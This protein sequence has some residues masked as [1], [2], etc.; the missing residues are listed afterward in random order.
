MP[1]TQRDIHALALHH[2]LNH[3]AALDLRDVKVPHEMD[4]IHKG[5][6]WQVISATLFE[7]LD[8]MDLTRACTDLNVHEWYNGKLFVHVMHCVY[9]NQLG[10]LKLSAET[11][12]HVTR[13]MQ[14]IVAGLDSRVAAV[15]QRNKAATPN[16]LRPTSA[17]NKAKSDAATLNHF[18]L[19]S[20][21]DSMEIDDDE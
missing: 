3:T 14:Y 15:N 5:A 1:L 9:D 13:L 7:T 21:E 17:G 19:L 16:K 10:A 6:I 2:V 8:L 20:Q 4:F 12:E 11:S 18:E